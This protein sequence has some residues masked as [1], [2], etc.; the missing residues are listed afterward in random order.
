MAGA[1]QDHQGNLAIGYS[2]AS[3]GKKP[4]IVYTGRAAADAAGVFRNRRGDCSGDNE[5]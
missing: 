1:A 3:E 5:Q 2:T 4:S